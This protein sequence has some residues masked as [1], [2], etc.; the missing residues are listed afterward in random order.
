MSIKTEQ[1]EAAYKAMVDQLW[2]DSWSMTLIGWD[3][4]PTRNFY[5]F[6]RAFRMYVT[7]LEK[8]IEELEKKNES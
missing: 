4:K 6:M 8:R 3:Y 5:K 2:N 1:Q 7:M